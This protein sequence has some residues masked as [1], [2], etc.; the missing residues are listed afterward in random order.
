MYCMTSY[1][2]KKVGTAAPYPPGSDGPEMDM[3]MGV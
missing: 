2:N 3:T 1:T